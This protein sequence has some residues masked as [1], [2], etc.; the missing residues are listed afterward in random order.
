M[1]SYIFVAAALVS[2]FSVYYV[3]HRLIDE[4]KDNQIPFEK[5]QKKF[6]L[7]IFLSKIVPLIFL[8]YGIIK[9]THKELSELYVPWAIIGITAII[10]LVLLEKIKKENKNEATGVYI[11]YL[12]TFTRPLMLTLP[13]MS[14]AFLYLM[15]FK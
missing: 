8:V 7:G 3:L 10:G 5:T 11:N 14:I 15:T 2:I 12:I 4:I 13:I 1:N 9:M 6:L